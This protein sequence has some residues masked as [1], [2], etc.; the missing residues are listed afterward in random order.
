MAAC[1]IAS[2]ETNVEQTGKL[3]KKKVF[4]FWGI[5]SEAYMVKLCYGLE[6]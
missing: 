2:E 3:K 1:N 5:K 4:D 6:I